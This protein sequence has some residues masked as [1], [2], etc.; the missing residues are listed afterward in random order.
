MMATAHKASQS[1]NGSLSQHTKTPLPASIETIAKLI[2][3]DTT[4]YKTNLQLIDLVDKILSGLGASVRRTWDESKNKANIFATIGPSDVPGIVLSGHT[5]VVPVDGQDWSRDPFHL[6]QAD[7]K[8]YGRGTADMK[9]FI[10]ICLAMA[11]QFAAAPLRMPVHFAFSY[12]EE[13]GCVGVRRL[14]DD[15]AHLPVRPALCIVGEPTDMKAVI[16]HKGKKSVRCHVEGHECHSALNHQGV[17]AIE[18]AAEMVTRLRALQRRIREQGPFDLGYQPPY[19]TVHT[20]T[21]QGGTA[22]N[23]VP[24]SCSFEFEIRNLPDH[25][26]E[27]LMAEVRGWAQDLVPEMLAVSEA[28][29]ITLDEHNSTPGLGMDEMDAAV[30]LVCALSGANQTSKVAF[31]TEAGLFQQAGIPAVVIGPGSIT[32][33]HRPDEFIT[34]EQVAQCE[35]FLRRLL[36]HMC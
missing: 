24:K 5:D 18:I 21:M 35:D 31:T 28:S 29:G 11:P 6:V 22:L 4:S 9:S 30:R 26:P 15:L 14:I 2:A 32:Q 7:G 1:E 27:T 12:D 23:I 17:N 36:A 16:G 33:A 20:G 3:I 13:V 10:A 19:T 8:L 34:L 25:D